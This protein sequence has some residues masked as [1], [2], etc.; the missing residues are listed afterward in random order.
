MIIGITGGS[1]SGK[2]TA[3]NA[4][5]ELGGT[6]L[7]CDAIYHDLLKT[8]HALLSQIECR[9]PGT[10]ENGVLDRKKLGSIVFS[11]AKALEDLNRITHQAVKDKVISLLT[12]APRLA[13]IDA[14]ALF[15]SGLSELCQLTVAVIAPTQE[16]ITR[17]MARDGIT[18]EYAKLR[19]QAQKSDDW[20]REKCDYILE[21]TGT[22]AQFHTKCLAFFEE[23][24]IMSTGTT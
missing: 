4:I 18:E 9:F 16:R 5:H 15:E 10:V 11:H 7:D 19:I 3:L 22:Q 13:A 1:G 14:I 8:D 12:P 23:L 17:L 21:N 20:F 2:T 24:D 6:V